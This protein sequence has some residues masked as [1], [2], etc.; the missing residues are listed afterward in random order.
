MTIS[1]AGW[2]D[3]V[4]KLS[5][6]NKKAA[7]L[8]Q[9]WIDKNGMDDIDAAIRYAYGLATK[10]G[11]AAAALA[12][13][14]Y[15][16][17]AI[18]SAA[19]LPPALPAATATYGEVAKAVEGTL[20]NLNNT[21]PATV[22]RLTKQAAADTTLQNA[23]RDGAQ[24]AWIPHGDTCAFCIM[25]ASNG[26]QRISKRT[27]KNGHAEHIHANCD[28]EYAIRFDSDSSV[29]GYDP[30]KYA[31]MYYGAEGRTPTEKINALRRE[32]YAEN[33][34]R[35]NAQKRDAY[36]KRKELNSSAAEEI[37]VD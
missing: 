36:E 29:Q 4:G 2:R 20:L 22:S 1:E 9:A 31:R 18:A 35:I 5:K 34:D 11:E 16:A 26:W 10:Y 27:L 12:C 37:D 23:Q 3:Y 32:F 17:A 28:C 21:V 14:M 19:S 7:D 30:E 6:I 33:K 13:E 15:D 8:M 25:L 24:F